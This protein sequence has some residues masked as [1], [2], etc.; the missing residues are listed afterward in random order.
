VLIGTNIFV[1]VFLSH[2]FTKTGNNKV[3]Y[4]KLD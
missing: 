2:L 3:G 1:T 4:L